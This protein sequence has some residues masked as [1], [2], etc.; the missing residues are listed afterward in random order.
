MARA[1]LIGIVGISLIATVF[2]VPGIFVN[3]KVL[4]RS[5][6]EVLVSWTIEDPQ[7]ADV[8]A[9]FSPPGSSVPILVRS[10]TKSEN[11]NSGV[12]SFTF[13]LVNNRLDFEFQLLRFP[14]PVNIGSVE[15]TN[16]D[17]RINWSEARSLARSDVV[18]FENVNEPLQGHIALTGDITQ[19]LVM[20]VSN[21]TQTPSV[22]YGIST[23]SSE[24][25]G[26]FK[27]YTI[28]DLC[29]KPA[30][31]PANFRSPGNINTVLLKNLIPNTV[32]NYRFGNQQDGWSQQW[33]F[34]T[35]PA[36]SADKP[37][38][39]LAFGDMG[40]A[41]NEEAAAPVSSNMAQAVMRGGVD[42]A[43]HIGDI[44]YAR[45]YATIWEW[46]FAE[47]APIAQRVP[48]MVS[49]GNHEFDYI[50][51]PLRPIWSNFGNDSGGECGVPFMKRFTMPTQGT[52]LWYSFDYGS[53]HFTLMSCE[54]EWLP[55]SSQ[56]AWL[57]QD[58]ATV[59]RSKTPWVIFGGHRPFYQTL[60]DGEEDPLRAKLQSVIEPMLVKYKVDLALWGHQHY[61]DR[62]CKMRNYRCDPTGVV[63]VIIGMAG[64]DYQEA[65]KPQPSWSI[66]RSKDFG[67]T[68][69]EAVNSTAM[70]LQFYGANGTALLDSFWVYH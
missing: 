48:Y 21:S 15:M 62:T 49:I 19:M 26:T 38:T 25:T 8:V 54:H 20:W 39:F 64:N 65:W 57:E 16:A 29:N 42:L 35:A 41:P 12:G 9:I 17:T 46:F 58:L 31:D 56:M 7:A 10:I 5:G 22:Q 67:Y 24:T 44:S 53:V 43:L 40:V 3:E 70:N 68:R 45:G 14:S 59:D 47:I 6:Q 4:Q 2:A 61:Y 30:T 28:T 18:R 52:N 27:T 55:G 63:N 50:L 60:D 13:K 34:K 37:V 1:T 66:S 51:Q 32:Y 11:W 33:N 69:I 36:V 23:M